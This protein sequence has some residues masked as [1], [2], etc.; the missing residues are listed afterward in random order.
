V[1]AVLAPEIS[2]I[3]AHYRGE[4]AHNLILEA[5][6]KYGVSPFY[7]L[8]PLL[9]SFLQVP[10]LVAVFNALGE[11]PQ[12]TG[13]SFLWITD[14]AYPDRVF[15]L[16]WQMPM[17]GDSFNVL[18]FVMSF[19]ALFSTI[20]FQNQYAPTTEVKQQKRNLYLMVLVFFVLF[21]PFPAVM[22]LYWALANILQ[23]VQQ[24]IIK[25]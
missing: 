16:P 2:H 15:L 18:P 23:T 10:I 4:E 19:V 8:K 5:Y 14:L 1:Q 24:Q 22:V 25:I 7:T 12:F 6:K 9:V 17:F 3:K 11:M 13:S 21:Y 20:I